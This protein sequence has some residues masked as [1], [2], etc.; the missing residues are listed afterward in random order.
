MKIYTDLLSG[1][2]MLSDAF[3]IQD[4]L[5]SEGNKVDLNNKNIHPC[6]PT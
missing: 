5:D 1:D 3:A 2:E 6:L 4:V